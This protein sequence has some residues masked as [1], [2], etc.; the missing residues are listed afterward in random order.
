MKNIRHYHNGTILT[1][2]K[3]GTKYLNK[4]FNI[5]GSVNVI[6]YKDLFSY[7]FKWLIV[8]D[9]YEHLLSA[10]TTV[11]NTKHNSRDL[12]NIITRFIKG[13]DV[14]WNNT[15][16]R[17]IL[18][19]SLNHSFTLVELSNLTHFVEHELELNAP[20]LLKRYGTQTIYMTKDTLIDKI[21]LEYPSEWEILMGLVELEKSSYSMLF[22]RCNVYS[23]EFSFS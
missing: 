21:K 3:C 5:T 12:N 7:D 17:C 22:D 13:L 6:W 23:P 20:P 18:P 14:H 11:Y 19:H 10:I 4:V 2:H 8:R 9:P 16:Y 1:P 15:F